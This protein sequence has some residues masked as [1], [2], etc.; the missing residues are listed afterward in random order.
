[1]ECTSLLQ[2]AL[3]RK[4]LIKFRE[5]CH[6]EIDHFTICCIQV[7][8]YVRYL[9]QQCYIQLL[10]RTY[11]KKFDKISVDMSRFNSPFCN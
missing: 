8:V 11:M 3:L 10:F 1:M 5:I 2:I 9:S 6:D 7:C 4:I